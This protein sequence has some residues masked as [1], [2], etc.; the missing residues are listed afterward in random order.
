M[1]VD[2]GYEEKE[3]LSVLEGRG[4]E[5]FETDIVMGTRE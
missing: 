5:V 1:G 4:E 2:I 3:F